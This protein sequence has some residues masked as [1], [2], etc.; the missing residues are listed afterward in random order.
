MDDVGSKRRRRW[1]KDCTVLAMAALAAVGC[2]AQ[3]R[4]PARFGGPKS[5]LTATGPGC[6][7]VAE[8]GPRLA[9]PWTFAARR[10]GTPPSPALRDAAEKSDA[11]AQEALGRAYLTGTGVPQD[12]AEGTRWTRLAADRG[13]DRA[14]NGL[15]VQYFLGIGVLRDRAEALR[16]ARLAAEGG[17][18]SGAFLVGNFL[19]VRPEDRASS[20]EWFRHAAAANDLHAMYHVGW[21][22]ERGCGAPRDDYEAARW[23]RLAAERGDAASQNKMGYLAFN[24][25]GML[26]DYQEALRWFRLAAGQGDA[27]GLV[28]VGLMY[29]VGRGVPRDDAEALRWYRRAAQKGSAQAMRRIGDFYENGRSVPRDPGEALRWYALAAANGDPAALARS[30]TRPAVAGAKPPPLPSPARPTRPVPP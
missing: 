25:F 6:G 14:R 29:A 1:G 27:D 19:F 2:A 8:I 26:Q 7:L 23:Y 9:M 12:I 13:D 22:Y 21:A 5:D 10:S 28:N 17:D 4:E 15:A 30:A 18:P 20:F 24:G 11:A 3:P 16:L